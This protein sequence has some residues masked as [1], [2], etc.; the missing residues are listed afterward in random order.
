MKFYLMRH[1]EAEFSAPSDAQRHLTEQGVALLNRRLDSLKQELNDISCII[2]SPY[3]RTLETAELVS[4]CLNVS[5]LYSS[6][7]WTPDSSPEKALASLEPYTEHTPLIVTHMP[8]VSYVEALC[9]DGSASYSRS[10][11]CGEISSITTDWP[12]AGLGTLA[13]RY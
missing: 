12:A 6:D 8:I 9:C 5:D 3:V 7:L 10:F 1:G 2:H 13:R 4:R 11:A